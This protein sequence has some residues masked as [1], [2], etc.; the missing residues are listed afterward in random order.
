MGLD[1]EESDI[2]AM[3]FLPKSDRQATRDIV[4]RFTNRTA[5]LK[6]VLNKKKASDN[7]F[8]NEHLTKKNADIFKRARE[9]RKAGKVEATWTRNCKVIVRTT[10]HNKP[11][12]H[13]NE[14]FSKI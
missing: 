11:G 10:D 8:I 12:N 13:G 1:V 6:V 2:S 14:W 9:L 5:K 3:H 7:V 4:V